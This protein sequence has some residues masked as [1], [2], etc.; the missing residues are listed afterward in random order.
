MKL[1]LFQDAMEHVCRIARIISTSDALLVGVGGSGK[2]SLA[3]LAAYIN[4]YDVFQITISSTYGIDAF[5]EDL[6]R[7]YD[8][9][10]LKDRKTM[11]LFTDTQ[12]MMEEFLV[13]LNDIL[14]SG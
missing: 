7:L 4:G 1:V 11:F 12:I 14:S 9:T 5:K 6:I 13:Y 8:L 2:Q 10:G 3:K